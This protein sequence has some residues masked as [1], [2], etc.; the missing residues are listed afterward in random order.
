M[1]LT[2]RRPSTPSS[3]ASRRTMA[4]PHSQAPTPASS[5]LHIAQAPWAQTAALDTLANSGL[6]EEQII[7]LRKLG[8]DGLQKLRKL[9]EHNLDSLLWVLT[10]MTEESIRDRMQRRERE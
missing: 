9:E 10:D 4:S 5:A 8:V 1:A 3:S 6:S 2:P 7:A